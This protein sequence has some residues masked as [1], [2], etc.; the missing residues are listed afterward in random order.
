[1]GRRSAQRY[2]IPVGY[3]ISG[4]RVTIHVG[5]PD[6]KLWWRNLTD[7]GAA[8]ELVV[9]GRR[10]TGHGVASREGDQTI[11]RVALGR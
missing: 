5:S 6:R 10:V 3:E 8:V 1:M 9:G 7:A 11:V 4:D 2:T